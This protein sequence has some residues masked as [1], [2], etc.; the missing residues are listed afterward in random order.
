M[1]AYTSVNLPYGALS[2]EISEDEN[3]N[4]NTEIDPRWNKLKELK[5]R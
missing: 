4:E 5:K 2:T 1:T 3:A